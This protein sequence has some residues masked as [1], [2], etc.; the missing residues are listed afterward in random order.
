MKLFRPE[1]ITALAQS[2]FAD[3]YEDDSQLLARNDLG[4]NY[5]DD[6]LI[7]FVRR[8]L[9]QPSLEIGCGTGTYLL[10]A[11]I[12][13]YAYLEPSAVRLEQLKLNLKATTVPLPNPYAHKQGVIEAIPFAPG[14]FRCVVFLNGFFQV[15]SDYEALIEVNRVLQVGGRFIF[16]IRQDD[17]EDIICGRILGVR[18]Y[19]R[20]LKEFGFEAY[21]ARDNG[22]ICARKFKEFDARDLRK[23]QLVKTADGTYRALNFF[24]DGRDANLV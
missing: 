7:A 6:D 5:A 11:G 12:A 1:N 23:L 16:N 19:I 9:I 4:Q 3:E 21:E 22:F 20:I 2:I 8:N 14:E 13:M 15:R 24:P 17:H 18:N 10:N